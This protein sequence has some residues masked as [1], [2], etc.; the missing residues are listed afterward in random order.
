MGE[1]TN[2][3]DNPIAASPSHARQILNFFEWVEIPYLCDLRRFC[4]VIV[5]CT[6]TLQIKPNTSHLKPYI[7]RCKTPQSTHTMHLTLFY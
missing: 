7:I 5:H 3:Q 6:T 4:V 2:K 1:D